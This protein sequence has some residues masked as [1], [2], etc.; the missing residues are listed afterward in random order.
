MPRKRN[1]RELPEINA[2][3]MADVAFLLLAFFLM[4]TTMNIDKGIMVKLP[5]WDP[6]NVIDVKV[7][8][9][10]V[11]TVLVNANDELLVEGEP[12]EVSK[13]REAA[14]EFI[15]NPYGRPDLSE[16]PQKAVISLKT[17]RGTSYKMYITVYNELKA[18]YRE[19]R[20]EAAMKK[21]GVPF[22]KLPP[23]KQKEIRKMYPIKISEAEPE[24]IG[25][26]I[27]G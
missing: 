21:Y 11:F 3:S 23:D 22:D 2:A 10:N 5:P 13:L 14:K 25:E 7:A 18:A 15:A 4:T 6:E 12:M 20:D 17:D 16:S 9:R 26:Q 27:G 19:L 24:A 1:R 8:D